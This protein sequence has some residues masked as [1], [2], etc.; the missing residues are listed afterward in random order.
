MGFCEPLRVGHELYLILTIILRLTRISQKDK[1]QTV[2]S[3]I[4]LKYFCVNI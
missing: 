2:F 4:Q 1:N 3:L